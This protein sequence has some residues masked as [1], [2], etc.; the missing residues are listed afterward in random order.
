MLAGSPVWD[1]N[2]YLLFQGRRE[3]GKGS[4]SSLTLLLGPLCKIVDFGF[5]IGKFSILNNG[6]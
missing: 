1:Q 4:K 3:G 6:I 2:D 5:S